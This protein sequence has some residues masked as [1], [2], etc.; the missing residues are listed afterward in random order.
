MKRIL[1][2]S[3]LIASTF[4]TGCVASDPGVNMAHEIN[5]V[6]KWKF[7]SYTFNNKTRSIGE[8]TYIIFRDDNTFDVLDNEGL[9]IA[10]QMQKEGVN[11]TTKYKVN[12]NKIFVVF[13]SEE[14]QVDVSV[15]FKFQGDKILLINNFKM[16]SKDFGRVNF[17]AIFPD[18]D[19]AK[20]E[21]LLKSVS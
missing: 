21:Y 11:I 13:V 9:L 15:N 17:N 14:T 20:A 19:F 16:K 1:M 10:E 7:I 3:L 8:E 18:F 6:G 5:L 2:A 4:L 12:G